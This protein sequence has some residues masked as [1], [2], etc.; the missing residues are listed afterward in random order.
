M[1]EICTHNEGS[2]SAVIYQVE[3]VEQVKDIWLALEGESEGGFFHSWYWMSPWLEMVL[4]KTPVYFFVCRTGENPYSCCLLTLC[5]AHRKKNLV[6]TLQLQI[7]EYLAPGYD[8]IKAYNGLLTRKG[9]AEQAWHMFFKAVD[10]F[11][12]KWDEILLSAL[13]PDDYQLITNIHHGFRLDVEKTTY[14]WMKELDPSSSSSEALLLSCKKKSRKQLKQSIAAFTEVCAPEL[15][16]ATDTRMALDYFRQMEQIHTER[17]QAVGEKGSFANPYWTQFHTR[18]IS[19]CFDSGVILMF[20]VSCGDTVLG[21]LYGHYYRSRVYMHQ[22][23]FALMDD[24]RFRPGYVSHFEAMRHCAAM[25][26]ISYD[27]L[28]DVAESYKKFF[29]QPDPPLQRVLL[30]R[31]RPV[32]VLESTLE[33]FKRF[34][35]NTSGASQQHTGDDL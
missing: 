10:G 19:N 13:L 7:N 23:G 3:S 14:C 20:K 30:K 11:S 16:A 32:F 4:G 35:R 6:R 31:S 2:D 22:T 21:Y 26:A 29:T 5:P 25:G 1:K 15:T 8:M 28:P 17:W 33:H 24:N 9:Q 12:N 27:L 18:I 34:K